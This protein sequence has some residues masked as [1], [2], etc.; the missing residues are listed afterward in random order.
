MESV[1]FTGACPYMTRD[2]L[3][4]KAS[5]K[6]EVKTSV[7]KDLTILV[8]ADP[9]SGSSKLEKA[10]KNGT[11]VI[12]YDEFLKMLD[13]SSVSEDSQ[14]DE[15]EKAVE[16]TEAEAEESAEPVEKNIFVYASD[17]T[18][19]K[20]ITDK[21]IKSLVI[22]E[23]VTKVA[24]RAFADCTALEEVTI[25]SSMV[26][27][28]K[29]AFKNCPSLLT[30]H[31][32]D[33]VEKLSSS[34]FELVP[35]NYEIDCKADSLSYKMI[36]RSTVLKAHVKELAFNAAKNEKIKEV[37]RTSVEAAI[38]VVLEEFPNARYEIL[39]NRKTGLSILFQIGKNCG[40]FKFGTDST[41]WI[42]QF[43]KILEIL[44]NQDKDGAE[45]FKE[46]KEN[47]IALA[48]MTTSID[49]FAVCIRS[50][51]DRNA[52]LFTTGEFK[53]CAVSAINF[54]VYGISKITSKAFASKHNKVKNIIFTDGLERIDRWAFF[55]SDIESVV[56]PEGL[57][58]IDTG[59]FS[60]CEKLTKV[61]LPE[62]LRYIGDRAFENCTNLSKIA[63][64][65]ATEVIAKS[66]FKNTNIE[67]LGYSVRL[68]K[69]VFTIK[70]GF[71]F[72]DDEFLYCTIP[73]EDVVI[74][75]GV[76]KIRCEAFYVDKTV[77]SVFIPKSVNFIDFYAFFDCKLLTKI[78]FGG[79]MA[80]WKSIKKSYSWNTVNDKV[81]AVN[82][83]DGD[84][85]LIQEDY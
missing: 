26:D 63:I 79:T 15:E 32:A 72:N 56:L 55:S 36:K 1:C 4:A 74:L 19:I 73:K 48:E 78:C 75:D 28:K 9:A 66:A 62:S 18:T 41:K 40:S 77:K 39:T 35:R 53:G 12:N 38:S 60:K 7:T 59:A 14:S 84:I 31:L 37:Q 8:C 2:A 76:S 69:G 42:G 68:D 6:F 71:A 80:E 24:M 30:I 22:A 34:W 83:T 51:K 27:I 21:S 50:D 10:K 64:P 44:Q 67:N 13:G 85:T 49:S 58:F 25:P 45:I 29:S 81:K 11:K 65:N 57:R 5:E 16:V 61:H 3:T 47:K 70:D 46:L 23:G 54:T 20:G 52:N 17:G 33:N 43:R 82:C